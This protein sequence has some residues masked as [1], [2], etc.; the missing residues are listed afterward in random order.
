[1]AAPK[2]VTSLINLVNTLITH[3]E[4]NCEVSALVVRHRLLL[5]EQRGRAL[6]SQLLQDHTEQSWRGIFKTTARAEKQHTVVNNVLLHTVN[7]DITAGVAY[8]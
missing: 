2:T 1:M 6:E 7:A 8:L 5:S 4:D 3:F